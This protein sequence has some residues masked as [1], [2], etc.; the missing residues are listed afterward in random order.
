[1]PKKRYKVAFSDSERKELQRVTKAGVSPARTILRA[2]I[3]LML[4][5]NSGERRSAINVAK[6]LGT[7]KTTVQ[8][9]KTSFCKRGLDSTL[10]RK[11]RE[12]PPVPAKITGDVAARIIALR[13]G[14][15]PAGYSRWTLRLLANKVVE[16]EII[17][18]ISHV[19]VGTI[20]KK[21]NFGLI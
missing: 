2:N 6:L 12:T 19:S 4:D 15:P 3:L 20:L 9:V 14:D 1:M 17:D 18:T 16:L 13:C 21:T 11:K 7:T 8:N 5:E 10:M